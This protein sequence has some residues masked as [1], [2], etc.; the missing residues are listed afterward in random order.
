MLDRLKDLWKT[1]KKLCVTGIAVVIAAGAYVIA[2]LD[3]PV[4]TIV[5]KIC[6]LSGWC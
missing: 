2:G 3:I 6:T 4:D 5:D 1:H